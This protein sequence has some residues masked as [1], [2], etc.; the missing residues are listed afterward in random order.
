VLVGVS[1][2]IVLLSSITSATAALLAAVLIGLGFGGEA[3]ITPYLLTRYFGLRAF[4]HAVRLHLDGI[5][6]CGRSWPGAHGQSV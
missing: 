2:G 6:D 3:D 1:V 4:S 5:R